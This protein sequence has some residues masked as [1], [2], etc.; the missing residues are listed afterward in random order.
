MTGVRFAK[1]D[2]RL[3]SQRPV[4]ERNPKYMGEAPVK[5]ELTGA[6]CHCAN[7]SSRCGVDQLYASGVS[8][9]IGCAAFFSSSA[10]HVELTAS[11][12]N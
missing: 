1:R 5:Y 8:L 2:E 3:S 9:A 11:R 6:S 7:R 12:D 10:C 4:R